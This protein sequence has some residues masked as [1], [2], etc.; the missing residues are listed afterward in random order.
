MAIFH[1]VKAK[2]HPME[3]SGYYLADPLNL[4]QVNSVS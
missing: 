1:W 2:P 4:D 3:K